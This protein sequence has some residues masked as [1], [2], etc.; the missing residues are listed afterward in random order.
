MVELGAKSYPIYIGAGLLTQTDL[1]K[2]MLGSSNV[3]VT[4][5]RVAPL[6]L[7]DLQAALDGHLTDAVVLP[8]GEATKNIDSIMRIIDALT[9]SACGRDTTLIA[10]GGGVIGDITGFAASIYLRGVNFVQMPTT[11]LAQVDASVGGKTGVNHERGKNLI[12]TFH[13]PSC[14]IGDTETLRSLDQ[15]QFRSGLAEVIKHA[16]VAD[17]VF[18]EWLEGNMAELQQL[19]PQILHHAIARCCEIKSDIV[20]RDERESGP[21]AL[22]NLGHTF[23][24]AIEAETDYAW[25][26][27]E[28]VAAGLVLAARL[29]EKLGYID[30]EIVERTQ[31]LNVAAG[32]PVAAP[33]ISSQR[34]H[35]WLQ[36]DKKS[37]AGRLRFVLLNAIGQAYVVSDVPDAKVE[38]V[39]RT[40]H[41]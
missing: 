8:E 17:P 6:Y 15:R 10:L 24:H 12:G 25:L 30:T 14:V 18:F 39:L 19:K 37:A 29:S 5:N 21:R 11:L 28:A 40:A 2:P 26:H 23:A 34:W 7:A 32:L 13:Q 9:E 16:L 41:L 3:I 33:E 4:D 38:E 36:A 20:A 27:G 1:I 22:L 35:S 31:R